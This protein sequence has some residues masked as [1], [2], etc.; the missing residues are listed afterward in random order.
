MKF[1]LISPMHLLYLGICHTQA[2]V[3]HRPM[4]PWHISPRHLSNPGIQLFSNHTVIYQTWESH[5]GN[6]TQ[7][8]ITHMHTHTQVSV[9]PGQCHPSIHHTWA[10]ASTGHMSPGFLSHPD[11]WPQLSI[12]TG[13]L[14]HSRNLSHPVIYYTL[15]GEHWYENRI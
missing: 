11:I 3:T 12:L 7:A 15:K 8:P 4:T 10:S 14:S 13:H 2:S 5:S 6:N 9:T 1:Q